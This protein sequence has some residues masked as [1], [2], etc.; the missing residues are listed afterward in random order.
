LSDPLAFSI[1]IPTHNR[2][3]LVVR[4]VASALGQGT[5][6]DEIIVVDDGS[7][8][9]TE[10][11]LASVREKIRYFKIENAGP[12]AARNHGV[13][14]ARNPLVAF[15]DSDDEWMPGRLE[16]ARRLFGAVP[17]LLFSFSDIAIT[18][19]SGEIRRRFLPNWHNDPRAWDVILGPGRPFSSLAELPPGLQDFRVFLGN[20]YLPLVRA[21]YVCTSTVAVRRLEAGPALRFDEDLRLCE[22]WACFA[23]LA[24]RGT[25]GYLDVE[26]TW[27][28]AHDGPRLTDVQVLDAAAARLAV[29]QRLWG[30]D[31]VFLEAHGETFRELV[32]EERMA[33]ARCLIA[34]GRMREAREELRSI[35]RGP[36]SYRV[37]SRLPGSATRALARLRQ[38]LLSRVRRQ[39]R[40]E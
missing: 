15:L 31:P 14:L 22:D 9:G 8:D 24:K 10:A 12:G 3:G 4:A 6:E 29:L 20:M 34:A 40:F 38:A 17:D 7:T 25:A 36:L 16:L 32:D 19:R 5:P 23:R 26:T 39:S 1:V 27:Q 30:S 35:A 28:H 11:A 37:L 33:R 18:T 13:G 21:N 2:A